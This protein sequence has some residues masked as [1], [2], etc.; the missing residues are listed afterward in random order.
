[1]SMLNCIHVLQ[2]TK[3]V[4]PNLTFTEIH[5]TMMYRNNW[6]VG[7]TVMSSDYK[8]RQNVRKFKFLLIYGI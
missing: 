2:V 3:F 6:S 5:C 8:L 1:M 4:R 7:S